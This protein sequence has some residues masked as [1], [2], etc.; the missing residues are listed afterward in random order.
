MKYIF[1]LFLSSPIFAQ[2]K[3][4]AAVDCKLIKAIDPYTKEKTISSGFIQMQGGS[5]TIDA[6]KQE[7][8]ML[9]TISGV[10]KCFTD[11][12]MAT[13]F[14]AGTKMKLSQRNTGSMNCEGIFHFS[15][16]NTATPPIL[17]RRFSTQKI[18]KIV[19][20]GNNKKESTVTLTP[21]Q[22]Q[23]LLDL[24]HCMANESPTLLQ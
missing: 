9:F 5:L 13:I 22:Q 8:D 17:L 3:D 23:M 1:L 11:Q 2:T 7:V 19:F 14:F 18:E 15:F 20:V 16:R 21:E 24:S 6:T 4:S 12:S 10:D